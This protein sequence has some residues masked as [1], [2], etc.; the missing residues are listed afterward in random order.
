MSWLTVKN[1]N[2]HSRAVHTSE[3]CSESLVALQRLVGRTF[4]AKRGKHL[5]EWEIETPVQIDANMKEFVWAVCV[6]HITNGKRRPAMGRGRW[7]T[8]F[9][10]DKLPAGTVPPNDKLTP[11]PLAGRVERRKDNRI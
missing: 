7:R 9:H 8:V 3:M 11:L 4:I 5:C 1:K 6:V 10:L 2:G